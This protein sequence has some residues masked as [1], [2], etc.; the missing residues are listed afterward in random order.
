MSFPEQK[1]SD[2]QIFDH[3]IGGGFQWKEAIC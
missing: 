2:K 3:Y 1:I